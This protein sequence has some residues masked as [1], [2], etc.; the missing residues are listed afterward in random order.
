MGAG[1][2]G[3]VNG[4]APRACPRLRERDR[5]RV[6]AAAGLGP[7]A[8]DYSTFADDD[9]ADMGVGRGSAPAA[10]AEGDGRRHPAR[11]RSQMPS[12]SRSSSSFLNWRCRSA[13]FASRWA[14]CF[15]WSAMISAS[16][17]FALQLS[18]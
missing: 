2:E 5:L 13:W 12:F 3:H 14:W 15:F 9:A 17:R 10:L 8:A 4:G 16:V 18:A 11:V 1:L 7:A 6:R